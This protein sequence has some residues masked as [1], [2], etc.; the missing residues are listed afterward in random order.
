MEVISMQF[1][2]KQDS[3]LMTVSEAARELE[4]SEQTIRNLEGRG[5][6][7]ASRVGNGMRLFL[8][9]DVEKL[10]GRRRD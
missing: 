3:S 9:E 7:P 10:R 4:V 5:E 6:L 2:S 8:R 1:A